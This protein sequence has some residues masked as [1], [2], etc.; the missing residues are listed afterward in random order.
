MFSSEFWNTWLKYFVKIIYPNIG[1]TLRLLCTVMVLSIF[2]GFIIAIVLT[3]FN[4]QGLRPN[5]AIYK[6]TTFVINSICSFPMIILIVAISP[7]TK[8]VMGTVIG[9][10][11]AI[12]PLTI[13]AT[14]YIAQ[15]IENIFT[16]VDKQVIEAAR[17]F[18]ASDMQ[19]IFKVILKESVPYL[20]S[21]LVLSTVSYLGATTL[22]GAVGAG[23]LGAVALNYGYQS[24]NN[25]VLYTSVVVL[26]FI[27]L[28]IRAV[29]SWIYKISLK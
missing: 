16:G 7:I 1:A 6:T 15:T 11:A 14:P 3:M 8:I 18:G 2:F 28:A 25:M 23:G 29:G 9:E 10:K 26:F 20:I 19:I 5:K 4:P 27:V 21:A 24:F 12:F 22:A 13:A 17:S